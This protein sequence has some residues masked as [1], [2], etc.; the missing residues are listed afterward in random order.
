MPLTRLERQVFGGNVRRLRERLSLSQEE[1]GERVDVERNTVSRWELGH[2]GPRRS[3]LRRICGAFGVEVRDLMPLTSGDVDPD[4]RFPVDLLGS[5]PSSFS[6][7]VLEGPWVTTFTFTHHH[8]T[9]IRCHADVVWL[10][11]TSDRRVLG[12]NSPPEPRTEDR[13]AA[14]FRNEIGAELVNR[15]LVG[16]WKNLN[17]MR[18]FGT[19]H[20]AVMPGETVMQGWYSGFASDVEASTGPWTWVRLE[21]TDEDL[22]EAVL[23]D[24]REIATLLDAHSQYDG[25]L[26]F[27]AVKED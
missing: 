24:P 4:A 7:A 3:E 12:T 25:P 13:A 10:S 1:F 21:S 14:P 9:T 27:A 17:D 22:A 6:A 8:D 11:A 15:H 18:Y 2:N 26:P 23:K 5:I 19:L 16:H 20:L